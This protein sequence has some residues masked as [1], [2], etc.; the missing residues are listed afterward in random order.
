MNRI[1]IGDV[2][3]M[4]SELQD[5]VSKVNPSPEDEIIFVGDL[6]DKGPD[7]APT[8]K[9]VR[10]L[11]ETHNVVLVKGNHEWKHER[12]RKKLFSGDMSGAMAMKGAEEIREITEELSPED[13]RFLEKSP[14]YHKTGG[15]LVVHGGIPG[16]LRELPA[17]P[18]MG[19]VSSKERGVFEQMMMTRFIDQTTGKMLSLGFQKE[20]D[21]YWAEVYDGRFGR[22][23]FGHEPFVGAAQKFPH[24][25]GVD[26]GAVYGGG[27]SALLVSEEG[28]E[29]IVS[30]PSRKH[31]ERELPVG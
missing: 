18:M 20:G 8:V 14:T 9:F 26:S 7:C 10:E 6:V 27:L 5:L 30:V 22:V 11:S 1:F 16:T 12:F 3:G 17:S 29:A 13:I 2:H 31:H 23:V 28:T 21:P 19:E 24:A 4:L 15:Y 25:V